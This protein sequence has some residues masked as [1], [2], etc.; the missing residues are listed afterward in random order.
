MK[1]KTS[2]LSNMLNVSANTIRRF[3]EKGFLSPQRNDDNQYRYFENSD[4]EKIAYISKYRK[5]G[6]GHEEIADIFESDLMGSCD[7]YEAKLKELEQEILRLKYL[8]HMV[9]DDIGLMQ[10]SREYGNAFLEKDCVPLHFV[11]YKEDRKMRKHRD[12]TKEVH[13][14]LY[15]FPMIKYIY[16]VRKDDLLN[17]RMRY[18]EAI[19]IR[20]NLVEHLNLDMSNEVIEYYPKHFSIMRVVRLPM[21]FMNE[22]TGKIEEV[23][24]LL[25]DNFFSY[26]NEKGYT[27]AGDAVG[28]KIGY[29]KEQGEEV[30]Y[31]LFSMPVH[32]D[33]Q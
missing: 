16:I 6:F 27:L 3:A 14:F 30:Q 15:E 9:M 24:T 10:R 33:L 20:T 22:S 7:I 23:K 19:A 31:V 17:R 1:Y 8:K 21:D 26:M 18:E 11:S 28:V 29:F 5:I 2:D 12:V 13:R 25:Y 32:K 4:V